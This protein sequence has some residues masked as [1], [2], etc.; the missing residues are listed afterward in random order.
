MLFYNIYIHQFFYYNFFGEVISLKYQPLNKIYYKDNKYYQELKDKRY[1][2]EDTIH[3]DFEIHNNKAFVYQNVELFSLMMKIHKTDKLIQKFR[4]DLPGVAFRQFSTKCLIDEIV[5]TND[6]EGV[7]STRREINE[8]LNDLSNNASKKRFDG[9]VRKYVKLTDNSSLNIKT[10]EDIRKIYDELVLKE[11]LEED[12]NDF[13][14]GIIFRKG[15]VSVNNQFQKEIHKGVMPES[16]IIEDM[17]RALT[18]LNSQ[19][20][21]L[22]IRTSIFHYLFGYIHPFYNGNGRISRFIS[23]YMLSKELDP[24]IGYRISGT[25]KENIKNYYN[26]FKICNDPK[27]CGDLTPFIISFLEIVDEAME[28]LFDALNRR[29]INL[30]RCMQILKNNSDLSSEK[31]LN[32]VFLLVQAGLFSEHGISTQEL[33]I[34]AKCSYTTLK[35]RLS[36]IN[37]QGL[38]LSQ[39]N[40]KE[41]YYKLDISKLNI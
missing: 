7:N 3:L 31:Y 5:L 21:D 33:C 12:P 30:E 22:L 28:Q 8:A 1:N 11:V 16:K 25:I 6:I 20:I 13:P 27:S 17:E 2:N 36:K 34:N 19:N 24:L 23:S 38:L 39:K 14:D 15:A 9:L 35:N 37:E 4:F 10:C 29:S 32:L 41:R 40:G 26:A 18:I